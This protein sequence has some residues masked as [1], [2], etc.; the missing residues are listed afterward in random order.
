MHGK[1][2]LIQKDGNRYVGDFAADAR[3]G[4]GVYYLKNGDVYEGDFVLNEM[5]GRGLLK[6]EEIE[7][8]GDFKEGKPHGRGTMMYGEDLKLKHEGYFKHGVKHGK[9][10]FTTLENKT[11]IT[12]WY[13]GRKDGRFFLK[14]PNGSLA[15]GIFKNDELVGDII[16]KFQNG[17]IYVGNSINAYR[18]G[19]GRMV[20]ANHPTLKTY[21]GTF[22]QNMMHGE[23]KL[24]LKNGMAYE[25]KMANNKMHG[26]GELKTA[27]YNAIGEFNSGKPIG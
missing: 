17:D 15:E 19:K 27:S 11:Y 1:G 14:S 2:E 22:S 16:T 3:T 6:T 7:Y 4:Q 20:W 26:A 8:R 24:T 5:K 18:E 9:G 23:G 25:G 13:M 12:T 10:Y 21:E